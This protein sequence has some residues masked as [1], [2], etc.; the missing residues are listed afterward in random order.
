M[1]AGLSS[2]LMEYV[3][4]LKFL[5]LQSFNS[6]DLKGVRK[7][8][9]KTLFI[10]L[11]KKENLV[12]SEGIYWKTCPLCVRRSV[13]SSLG[14]FKPCR[15]GWWLCSCTADSGP[16][17]TRK[18]CRSSAAPPPPGLLCIPA[19]ST[20]ARS[21]RAP[22]E[23]FLGVLFF[24]FFFGEQRNTFWALLSKQE[25]Q[26]CVWRVRRSHRCIF[27]RLFQGCRSPDP[28][29]RNLGR[30]QGRAS[31]WQ[32]GVWPVGPGVA[33]PSWF[34]HEWGGPERDIDVER[35]SLGTVKSASS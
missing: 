10:F 15:C 3:F 31:L 33:G 34:Q 19:R 13:P 22:G 17:S 20:P 14:C 9:I 29:G 26:Q 21:R 25:T 18:T 11:K 7:Y 6:F 28:D 35:V 16:S 12:L 8:I 1:H 27:Y 32:R 30:V 24:C 4:A 23:R 2:Y 5:F